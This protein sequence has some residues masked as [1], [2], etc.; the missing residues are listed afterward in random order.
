M[1]G[2]EHLTLDQSARS[3]VTVWW[4]RYYHSMFQAVSN[5]VK[6]SWLSLN[7]SLK[8]TATL[9]KCPRLTKLQCYQNKFLGYPKRIY[10]HSGGVRR[11]LGQTQ[12]HHPLDN[13]K[14]TV[15]NPALWDKQS[16]SCL[17]FIRTVHLKICKKTVSKISGQMMIYYEVSGKRWILVNG[18]HFYIKTLFPSIQLYYC[19]SYKFQVILIQKGKRKD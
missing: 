14:F 3:F 4:Q 10:H 5:S 7:I 16:F 9:S 17:Y 2:I 15:Y 8:L 1:S 6:F 13:R 12:Q 19:L 11:T 18:L